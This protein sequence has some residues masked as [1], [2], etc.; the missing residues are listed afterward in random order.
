MAITIL[1]ASD[2]QFGAPYLPEAGAAFV[3]LAREVAPDLVVHSW[4]PFPTHPWW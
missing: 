4:T 3:A 1:H 2:L